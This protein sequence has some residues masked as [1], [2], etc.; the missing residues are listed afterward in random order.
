MLMHEDRGGGPPSVIRFVGVRQ[1][2]GTCWLAH[3]YLWLLSACFCLL[4]Y[5]VN[6]LTH[7]KELLAYI[8]DNKITSNAQLD[9]ALDHLGKVRCG[10]WL[11]CKGS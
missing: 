3:Q 5:P 2:P 1:R 9:A 7:R 6:A 11:L 10:G 4:Q 8:T